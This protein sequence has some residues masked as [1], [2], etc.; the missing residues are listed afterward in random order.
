MWGNKSLQPWAKVGAAL[1][2]QLRENKKQKL[3]NMMVPNFLYTSSMLEWGSK[4]G[5]KERRTTNIPEF[6]NYEWYNNERWVI[7]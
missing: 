5:T 3:L 4:F 6:Q 1:V 7:R 2:W